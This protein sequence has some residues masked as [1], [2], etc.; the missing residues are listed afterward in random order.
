M[1]KCHTITKS[2]S[3]IKAS[4]RLTLN[5]YRLVLAAISQIDPRKPLPRP[6]RVCAHD[7]AELYGLPVKQAYEAIKEAC[8]SLYEQDVKTFD[9]RYRDRFRWVDKVSYLDGGGE[10]KLYFT[11]HV[12]PYLV[13]MNKEFTVYKLRRVVLLTSVH[14][15][16]FFELFQRFRS[17]GF[18]TVGVDELKEYLR[19]GC[20]YDRYSNLKDKVIVPVIRELREKSALHVSLRTERK[21]RSIKRLIFTFRDITDIA[22]DPGGLERPDAGGRFFDSQLLENG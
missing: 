20:S 10:A 12:E 17:T 3:L 4:Y 5:E 19:L 6:I 2:N 1:R 13:H 22:A 18:Y 11:I 21:G 9:G 16:R 14:S 7:F 8:N 15:I